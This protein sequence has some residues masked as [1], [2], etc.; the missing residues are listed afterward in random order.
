MERLILGIVG[1]FLALVGYGIW[2]SLRDWW[3]DRLV[4]PVPP[5]PPERHLGGFDAYLYP[6]ETGEPPVTVERL[7]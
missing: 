3:T 6:D 2:C 7:P 1:V 5:Q 4:R